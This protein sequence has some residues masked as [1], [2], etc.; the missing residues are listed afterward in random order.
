MDYN[1]MKFED[2]FEADDEICEVCG[3]DSM[4]RIGYNKAKDLLKFECPEC[5]AVFI[6]DGNGKTTMIK[7]KKRDWGKYLAENLCLP[8]EAIV[9]EISDE[10][11]FGVSAIGPIR[12]EDKLTVV[13]VDFEDDLHGVLVSV[14]K[15]KKNYTYPLIDLEP[16]DKNSSNTKLLNNYGSW[17]SC[18]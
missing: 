1:N 4:P 5:G 2:E 17:F 13:S 14:K 12:Y 18:Q 9:T 3:N 15:G 11:F 10:E 7:G 8:F 16:T 6:E